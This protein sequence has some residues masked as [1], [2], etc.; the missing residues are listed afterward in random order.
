MHEL[1]NKRV[2]GFFADLSLLQVPPEIIAE[3][4]NLSVTQLQ[5]ALSAKENITS[6]FLHDFYYQFGEQIVQLKIALL[7]QLAAACPLPLST[8]P[9][10]WL[11]LADQTTSP[12]PETS[13][14]PD[15][16]L[17]PTS[18]TES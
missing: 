17:P 9:V 1:L 7:D 16:T 10:D 11:S 13:G 6:S 8:S 15:Q 12:P 14:G 3:R 18:H 5:T 2:E 4:L